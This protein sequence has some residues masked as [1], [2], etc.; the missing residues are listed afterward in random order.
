[1]ENQSGAGPVV[2]VTGASTGFGRA[3][4]ERLANAGMTV[5]GTSRRAPVP[6]E[7]PRD[8]PARGTVTM[9]ALDVRKDE[10]V[11]ACVAGVMERAGRIDALINNAGYSLCGAVEENTLE[12]VKG[13]FETNFF[14]YVRMIREVLPM[15]RAQ[16]GGRIINV[17]SLAGVV[18]VPFHTHY[19][20]T[21][22]ALEGLSEGLRMEVRRFGIHVSLIEPADFR[23]E[24]TAARV[25]PSAGLDAYA[26]VRDRAV[27]IMIQSEQGGP[28][29]EAFA[30]LV[31]KILKAKKPKLRYRVGAD[32]QWVP[33]AKT[34]LPAAAYEAAIRGNYKLD[35]PV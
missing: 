32:A 25:Y 7:L 4:A 2:L 6:G 29:P 35:D 9:V 12:E 21:K 24:G 26:A 15:M 13:L 20:A 27:K 10:D 31:E 16:G 28:G 11:R 5:F 3:T 8:R 30:A 14:G 19:S 22:F 18:G 33:L 17:G 23:T 34:L 1:M